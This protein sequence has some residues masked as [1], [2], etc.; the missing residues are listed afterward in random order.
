M[1][2]FEPLPNSEHPTFIFEICNR[3]AVI[4]D[5]EKENTDLFVV[6]IGVI[7]NKSFAVNADILKRVVL[8]AVNQAIGESIAIAPPCGGSA[9]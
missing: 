4:A 7:Y 3:A 8:E 1:P 2:T 6:Q 9:H 5:S